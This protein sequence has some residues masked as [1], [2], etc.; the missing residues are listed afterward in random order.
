MKVGNKNQVVILS[1]LAIG[2]I[3]FL[4]NQLFPGVGSTG[5]KLL[6][7]AKSEKSDASTRTARLSAPLKILGDPF[8]SSAL[9]PTKASKNEA[10]GVED[11]SKHSVSPSKNGVP[12]IPKFSELSGGVDPVHPDGD[13][14]VLDQKDQIKEGIGKSTR[15]KLYAVAMADRPVAMLNFNGEDKDSIQLG[16]RIGEW[17]VTELNGSGMTLASPTKRVHLAIG[18]EVTL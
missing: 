10:A 16:S 2:S 8:S 15:L 13:S 18:Q 4:I 6:S 7:L 9:I 14:P 5:L 1:I 17:K 11:T 3:G 12:K